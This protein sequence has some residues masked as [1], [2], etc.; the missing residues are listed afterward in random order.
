VLSKANEIGERVMDSLRRS[1]IDA[2]VPC[3]V[4]G[5]G[6]MF[7]AV[8]T[9]SSDPIINYRGLARADTKRFAAFRKSLFGQGVLINGSGLACWFVSG[10]HGVD[11]ADEAIGAI[12]VAMRSVT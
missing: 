12:E 1:A 2:G 9:S 4:Q 10:A 6:T 11:E 8:F 3:V 5:F 7:Q